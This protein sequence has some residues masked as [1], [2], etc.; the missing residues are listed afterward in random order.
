MRKFFLGRNGKLLVS[1]IV[2]LSIISLLTASTF[3]FTSLV[4]ARD[5]PSFCAASNSH[6]PSTV[7]RASCLN[8]VTN[9]VADPGQTK[10]VQEWH[11]YVCIANI[12]EK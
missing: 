7:S 9:I 12:P 5:A 6:I 11:L 2:T 8:L 1:A 4:F 10:L 3:I